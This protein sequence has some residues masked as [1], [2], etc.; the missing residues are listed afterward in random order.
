M[1]T[2]RV[3]NLNI[4]RKVFFCVIALCQFSFTLYS[5]AQDRAADFPVLKGPYFGQ[6]IPGREPVLFAPG[7]I[8]LEGVMVHDTPVF[9]PDGDEIFWSEFTTDPNHTS[10]KYSRLEGDTWTPPNGVVSFDDVTAAIQYFMTAP[11]APHLTVVDIEPQET[12]AVLNFTDI[13]QIVLAFQSEPYP[14]ADP[15]DC[16]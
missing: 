4:M 9:T 3:K 8:S 12:N 14:F 6:K 7:V 1:T 2:I 13:M 5:W 16:P 15:G 11:S 10:I